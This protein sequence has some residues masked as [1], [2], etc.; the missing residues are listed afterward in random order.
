MIYKMYTYDMD[1]F[2]DYLF[3]NKEAAI[4][5]AKYFLEVDKVFIEGDSIKTLNEDGSYTDRG[6]IEEVP[7]YN[8]FKEFVGEE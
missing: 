7:V 5:S 3:S 2:E 4:E 8:T 6:I 1:D